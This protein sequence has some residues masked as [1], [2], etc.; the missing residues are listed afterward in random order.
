[1]NFVTAKDKNGHDKYD[2]GVF[3]DY[4]LF[5]YS[6]PSDVEVNDESHLFF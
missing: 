4:F 6:Q 3:I 1:V 5:I 2:F